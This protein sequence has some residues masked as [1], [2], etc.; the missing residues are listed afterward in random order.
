MSRFWLSWVYD[1]VHANQP[2]E[3]SLVPLTS[4]PGSQEPSS[5]DDE[6]QGEIA[7]GFRS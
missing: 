7:M 6:E 5:A 4:L 1:S 3:I 2:V